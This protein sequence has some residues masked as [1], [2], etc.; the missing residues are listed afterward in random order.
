MNQIKDFFDYIFSAF[1]FWVIVQPWEKG[2]II[3]NGKRTREVDPGI[4]FK[5]PYFDSVYIQQVRLRVVSCSMQT[6]TTKDLKTIT[7]MGA[8][9]YQITDVQ[10]LYATLYHPETTISNMVMSETAALVF[11]KISA[12][13][14]PEDLEAAVLK[15]LNA[16]NYGLSFE[17]FK[18]INFAVVRTYRLIQDQSWVA[19]DLKMDKLGADK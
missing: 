5:L 1:K 8:V 11:S 9:G 2:L 12:D 18:I 16:E 14:K 17:Y 3:R 4:Y 19:N 10:K 15:K 13:I 6:L 7:L